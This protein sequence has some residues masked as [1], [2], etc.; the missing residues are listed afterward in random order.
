MIE[1][2][3]D[4]LCSNPAFYRQ[5]TG[6]VSRSW[7]WPH[8]SLSVEDFDP[9]GLF[10]YLEF[11]YSVYGQ[12][13]DKNVKM[14]EPCSTISQDHDGQLRIKT[15]EDPFF[16]Y[17]DTKHQENE[18]FELVRAKV[19]AWEKN[20]PS[21]KPIVLPLSGGYDSRILLW[22][23]KDKERVRAYS[24]G[25]STH[26]SRSYEVLRAKAL[27][28]SLGVKWKHI[29]LGH[30]HNFIEQ[31]IR[32][33]GL[34]VHAH[35][36]YH[37]EFY[38]K[39]REDLGQDG[40]LLSGIF[41]DVWA[42]SIELQSIRSAEDLVKLGYRHGMHAD[43]SAS[44]LP[45]S[46]SLRNEYWNKSKG[47]MDDFRFQIVSTVRLKMILISYLL[48]TPAMFGLS[49]WSPF[50]D[51]QVALAMLNIPKERRQNRIWQAEFFERENLNVERKFL[52]ENLT[53]NLNFQA[54]KASPLSHLDTQAF[55]GLICRDYIRWI[56]RN[57]SLTTLNRLQ[58]ALYSHR[59]AGGLL[60]RAGLPSSVRAA[61]SAYLCLKPIEQ[62]LSTNETRP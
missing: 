11:G 23:I 34:S 14:L 41:G 40:A 53:N 18:I 33:Y 52:A 19:R 48:R 39:I 26:Q 21:D 9:E 38:Q 62:A 20:L 32:Q 45:R 59:S 60:K 43:S 46:Q 54:L 27:C 13:P 56:N 57:I 24:Y 51:P 2:E 6:Q 8:G 58:I 47:H 36:L 25:V 49:A 30:Y 31:W 42:G 28:E 16:K 3:T 29:P 10:N 1:L 4:W 15:H 22:A 37:C 35:G 7:I 44:L 17:I 50:T 5:D 55:D 61:Y 12:T